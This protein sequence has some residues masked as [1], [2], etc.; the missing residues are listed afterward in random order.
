MFHLLELLFPFTDC[1]WISAATLSSCSNLCVPLSPPSV[2]T[3]QG[4]GPDLFILVSP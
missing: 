4:S 3:S 1:V 2:R